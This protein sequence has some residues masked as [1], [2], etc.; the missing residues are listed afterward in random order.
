MKPKKM[1]AFLVLQYLYIAF[2][3]RSIKDFIGYILNRRFD[4]APR[5]HYFHLAIPYLAA[6]TFIVIISH[7]SYF[8]VKKDRSNNRSPHIR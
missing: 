1:I 5:N 7:I 4:E 6:L 3:I 2:A 8:K